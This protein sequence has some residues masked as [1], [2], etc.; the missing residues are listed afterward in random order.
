MAPPSIAVQKLDPTPPG[1]QPSRRRPSLSYRF[2]WE[3]GRNWNKLFIFW[4][5][6]CIFCL[7]LGLCLI[8]ICLFISARLCHLKQ[9]VSKKIGDGRHR[10]KLGAEPNKG[11]DGAPGKMSGINLLSTTSISVQ[12]SVEQHSAMSWR[13]FRP[14]LILQSFFTWPPPWLVWGRCRCPWRGGRDPCRGWRTRSP[15]CSGP[16]DWGQ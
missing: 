13:V 16:P 6:Y 14:K 10:Q 2:W 12:L 4:K 15:R 1:Q 11:T 7:C 5:G 8:G 9:E 3:W